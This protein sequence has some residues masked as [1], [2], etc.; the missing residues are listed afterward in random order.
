MILV[1]KALEYIFL[2]IPVFLIT[3]FSLHRV[4]IE[5]YQ[6]EG[7]LLNGF[8][9]NFSAQL[10]DEVRDKTPDN[11]SLEKIAGVENEYMQ[12]TDVGSENAETGIASYSERQPNIIV[13]MDESFADLHVLGENF[14]TR[15]DA[16][17]LR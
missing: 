12:K 10:L 2:L 11:Y 13:I 6:N 7:A 5:T 3:I 1:D 9:T 14:N 15:E 16:M 17:S 8:L 4:K